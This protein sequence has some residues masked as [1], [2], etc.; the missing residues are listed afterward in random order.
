MTR[1]FTANGRSPPT[2]STTPLSS[3]RSSLACASGPRSPTSS[4]NSVPP[5]AISKRP[6]RR[7]VAPV[8]APRSWPNISDSTRSRGSAALL[9]VTNGLLPRA[10]CLAAHHD[11][12]AVRRSF[13]DLLERREPVGA[14]RHHEV[15]QHHIRRVL[16]DAPERGVAVSGLDGLESI[17]LQ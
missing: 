2:R 1:T 15:E 10:L 6:W 7:S 9:T 16:D 14:R 17:R 8:K 11:H 12:G 5:S 4:R 13:A 3:T